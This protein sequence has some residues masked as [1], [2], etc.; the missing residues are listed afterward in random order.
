MTAANMNPAGV[1]MPLPKPTEMGVLNSIAEIGAAPVTV[2]KSTPNSPIA[3]LRSLGTSVRCEMSM[4]STPEAFRVTPAVIS[5]PPAGLCSVISDM[6][7][8]SS[9]GRARCAAAGSGAPR[10]WG[11]PDGRGSAR[12]TA[13]SSAA[14]AGEQRDMASR[15]IGHRRGEPHFWSD[16]DDRHVPLLGL[17]IVR[18]SIRWGTAYTEVAVDPFA[19]PLAY[20]RRP[21]DLTVTYRIWA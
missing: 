13:G 14:S 16:H 4:L 1:P 10:G 19:A 21:P 7:P 3:F 6:Q 9:V 2:R 18:A 8:A 12:Q 17:P 15:A 20:S 5:S 11:T